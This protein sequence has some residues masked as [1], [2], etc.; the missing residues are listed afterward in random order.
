M[1][2]PSSTHILFILALVCL[3][4]VL[5]AKQHALL[6]GVSDYSDPRIPDLEGPINDVNALRKVLIDNW[7]FADEDITVLTDAQATEA[8]ILQAVDQLYHDTEAGDDIIIYYSGHGTSAADPALGA[9]VN[10]PDGSG[11]IVASDFNP[12][13]LSQ[14]TLSHSSDDGLLVGRFEIRPRLQALDR[15]R[16]VLVMFDAC[17]S[18]NATRDMPSAYK[19]AH[20]RQINL[21]AYFQPS[22]AT[23]NSSV[24]LENKQ[25]QTTRSLT[26]STN[27][28]FG[29]QNTVYFGAA[30]EDQ[31][32]V[33]LSMAEIQAGLVTTFDGKPHGGF[34]DSL[35]RA[36]SSLPDSSNSISFIQLF[37]RTVNYFNTW[38]KSCGHTPVSLPTAGT[39]DNELLGRTILMPSAVLANN[40]N[41]DNRSEPALMETLLVDTT[42]PDGNTLAMRSLNTRAINR[43]KAK[44]LSASPDVYFT[45]TDAQL[46][47]FSA[48]G[49]LI[50]RMPVN[51]PEDSMGQWLAGR[52]WLKRRMSRDLNRDKGDLQVSFRQPLASN[53]V[54][55]GEFIHFNV[56]SKTPANLLMLL[57]NAKSELSVLYPVSDTERK[58]L[59]PA[60]E[61][62]RIPRLDEPAIQVTPPW[63]TDIVMFYTLPPEHTLT[64]ALEQLASL[65]TIPVSHP[66]LEELED[67]LDSDDFPY[68]AMTVRIVSSP[69]Q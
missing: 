65:S 62:Q 63:G 24:Q 4:T 11:A 35:L 48:D 54:T 50:T 39:P 51:M 17:F 27:E 28:S 36:L 69:S 8:N 46:N 60:L 64:S 18:G 34:T 23:A 5:Q 59:L 57:L 1:N 2:K 44:N 32:A 42:L 26:L 13:K 14:T 66:V 12:D 19:P 10:L 41:Y 31:F 43:V 53:H 52:E 22:I 33:D 58:A 15:E 25:Q 40:T 16:N 3:P 38:C 49:H 29:Y 45:Q 30:A 47:A 6:I 61:S 68:S 55:D 20:K 7:Q 56:M 21:N 67:A 37:N 9:R